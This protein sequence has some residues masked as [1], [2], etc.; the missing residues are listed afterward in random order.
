M[1]PRSK[2]PNRT[3]SRIGHAAPPQRYDQV[4][5]FRISIAKPTLQRVLNDSLIYSVGG[6][7]RH[8]QFCLN[9]TPRRLSRNHSRQLQRNQKRSQPFPPRI[10][11]A[12]SHAAA[13]KPRSAG[14]GACAVPQH[15]SA[16]PLGDGAARQALLPPQPTALDLMLVSWSHP[17]V[18]RSIP[19]RIGHVATVRSSGSACTVSFMSSRAGSPTTSML[20]TR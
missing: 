14:P 19:G 12:S 9:R 6:H 17:S 20:R 13:R 8:R 1:V 18:G 5:R 3:A 4:A 7:V 15:L 2:H 16:E 11:P 10:W